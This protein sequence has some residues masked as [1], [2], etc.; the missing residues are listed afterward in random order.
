MKKLLICGT[1]LLAMNEAEA[2]T[3]DN[4][5]AIEFKNSTSIPFTFE[6]DSGKSSN[7]CQSD[8][9]STTVEPGATSASISTGG[10]G[11]Y[12]SYALGVK[13]TSTS[14]ESISITCNFPAQSNAIALEGSCVF[15]D[16]SDNQYKLS[17][18]GTQFLSV[19]TVEE[20][21]ISCG[22]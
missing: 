16:S 7:W 19:L 5:G 6:Y 21:P 3:V 4:I 22:L 9:D 15:A 17:A 1:L 14:T 10:S 2:C 18:S 12:T 20:C 8:F 13:V 11:M